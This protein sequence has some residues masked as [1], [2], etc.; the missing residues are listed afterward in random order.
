MIEDAPGTPSLASAV[1]AAQRPALE[2]LREAWHA[3]LQPA[4]EA[5]LAVADAIVAQ[6]WRAGRLDA[7]EER[8]LSALLDGEAAPGL[9]SL[10]TL[11]RCRG[12]LERDRKAAEAELEAL[13]ATRPAGSTAELPGSAS[14]DEDYL[15]T[16]PAV[17]PAA[18]AAPAGDAQLSAGSLA[19]AAALA[20]AD[21]GTGPLPGRPDGPAELAAIEQAWSALVARLGPGAAVELAGPMAPPA[22]I[23]PITPE[24][25]EVLARQDATVQGRVEARRAAAG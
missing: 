20:P 17:E 16:E 25:L 22:A 10:A 3:R 18:S 19:L 8:I 11:L 12:R 15:W 14:D 1:R 24:M 9:P 13:R 4:D 5:E 6:T 7:L 23:T 21:G 2:R